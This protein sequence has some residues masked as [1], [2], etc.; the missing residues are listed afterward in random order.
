VT[1]TVSPT[2]VAAEVGDE[3]L[4]ALDELDLVLESSLCLTANVTPVL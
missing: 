2:L 1:T 3:V 4:D